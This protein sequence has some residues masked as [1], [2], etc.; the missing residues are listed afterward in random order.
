MLPVRWPRL[1][2]DSFLR[3]VFGE[4]KAVVDQE[5]Y[6]PLVAWAIMW[7][8]KRC[9]TLH[10]FDLQ[11]EF[12][13]HLPRLYDL[14]YN[15]FSKPGCRDT[16]SIIGLATTHLSW[17]RIK[18][19]SY[20]GAV[21]DTGRWTDPG[22]FVYT[23]FWLLLGHMAHH[24]LRRRAPVSMSAR[25]A[26]KWIQL[27]TMVRARWPREDDSARWLELFGDLLEMSLG[28]GYTD[29]ERY[30]G[31]IEALSPI[32]LEVSNIVTYIDDHGAAARV[33]NGNSF[34][35]GSRAPYTRKLAL[36]MYNAMLVQ[37]FRV[38]P[39]A[40]NWNAFLKVATRNML[41]YS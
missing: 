19:L 31:V 22:N 4:W 40:A 21:W 24:V 28:C 36:S 6:M 41:M 20:R 8:P 18:M 16:L 23:L 38:G 10:M 37:K 3:V 39:E 14:F 9:L 15:V 30:W 17:P 32:L 11:G 13:V 5:R 27:Q 26:G 1:V 29:Q 2:N 35:R 12:R 34:F 33:G 25:V 7:D